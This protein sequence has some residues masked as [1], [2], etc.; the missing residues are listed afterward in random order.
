MTRKI[1][2]FT[3]VATCFIPSVTPAIALFLGLILGFTIGNPF[4]KVSGKVSK[5]LLQFSVVGL[6]FG[7]NL[8]DSIQS[9]KEGRLITIGS[10]VSVRFLGLL[11]GK[12]LGMKINQL[13]IVTSGLL[14]V[15][16]GR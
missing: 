4:A 5:Y 12:L 8:F 9:G 10:V 2:F 14:I 16:C 15:V 7:M 6:G 3:L 13:L 11:V 1:I